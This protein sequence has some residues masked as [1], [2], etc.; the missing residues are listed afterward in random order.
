MAIPSLSI[1]QVAT[2]QF[3]VRDCSHCTFYLHGTQLSGIEDAK[4]DAKADL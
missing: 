1:A 3:R 2:K 4:A